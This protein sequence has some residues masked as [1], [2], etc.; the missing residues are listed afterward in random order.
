MPLD[1]ASLAAAI[2]KLKAERVEAVAVALLFSFL[3]PA[4][5]QRVRA[6][7]EAAMPG[8]PVSLSSEV[9]PVFREYERTVVTAFDAYVK[10][11]VAPLSRRHGARSRQGGRAGAAAGHA[12]ARRSRRRRRRAPAAGAALPVGTSRRRHWRSGGRP[13]GRLRQPHHHRRRR[14]L[15]RYRADRPRPRAR[16]A[17]DRHR[18][19]P[20]ARADARRDDARRRWRLDRLDRHGRRPQGRPPV[21]GRRSGASLLRPRAAPRLPSRMPRSCSGC[22]IPTTSSAARCVSIAALSRRA[23]EERVAKPLGMSVEDAAQGIHRIANAHMADGIRL[24][25]INRGYD[26]REFALVPLGGAG[27]LHAV[28]ARLGARHRAHH[29]AAL[30]RACWR[31]PDFSRRRSSTRC[32]V[33]S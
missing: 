22:S 23:V 14:H 30:S 11:I 17:G 12:V 20:G 16:A 29:R 2:D 32:R 13:G 5:E 9:D 33:P 15:E 19:L 7:I 25:S 10:P 21:G 24:V 28:R 8:V 27:G 4:H 3:N 26:P 31:R 6:A 18:R 1:E